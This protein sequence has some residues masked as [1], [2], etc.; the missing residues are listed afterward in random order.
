MENGIVFK[1]GYGVGIF[2]GGFLDILL[3]IIT[4][5]IIGGLFLVIPTLIGDFFQLRMDAFM[6]LYLLEMIIL[7]VLYA[8]YVPEDN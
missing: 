5:V 2:L 1:I 7:A 3:G 8:K 4:L 6:S